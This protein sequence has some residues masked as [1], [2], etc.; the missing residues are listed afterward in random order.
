MKEYISEN[1]ELYET[2]MQFLNN[3]D[4]N[5]DYYHFFYPEI[6]KFIGEEKL[7]NI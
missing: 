2:F 5:E 1:Q 3:S 6:K 7:K 4:S